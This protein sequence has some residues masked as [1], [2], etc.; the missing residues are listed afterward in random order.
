MTKST[1]LIT[2]ANKG[3]GFEIARQLGAR[4]FVVWLGSRDRERGA[5]A[6]A[7]LRK[8]GIEANCLLLDVTDSGSVRSAAKRLQGQLGALDALVNNAGINFGR[9]PPPS[10]ESVDQMRAIFDVNVF[11]AVSVTQAF[12]PLLRKSAA[13]RIVMIS[14]GLG[15]IASTLD[16]TSENWNVGSAGYCASKTAL[17]MITVKFAKELAAENIKVNAADPGLTATD[18]TGHLG[19]RTPADAAVV[20]VRLATL[21]KLGPTGGFFLNEDP[22]LRLPCHPW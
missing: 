14:S 11:G 13:A 18:L 20:A 7:E 2:G 15:S 1:A 10:Q 4:D 17:N 19:N 8:E 12:L 6:V 9:P 3:I 22:A 21:D 5:A 16:M